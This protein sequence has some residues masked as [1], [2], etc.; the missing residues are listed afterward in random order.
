[1]IRNIY[2]ELAKMVCIWQHAHN[3]MPAMV[4]ASVNSGLDGAK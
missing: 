3:A 2:S 1:M 4:K